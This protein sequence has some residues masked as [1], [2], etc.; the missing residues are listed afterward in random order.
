MKI[1]TATK[2]SDKIKLLRDIAREIFSSD[3]D[4]QGC[5]AKSG[6]SETPWER[7]TYLGAK[8]RAINA[9]QDNKGAD[10]GVG[11][12]TGLSRRFGHIFEETWCCVVDKK[13]NEFWGYASGNVIPVNI[14]KR[15]V[16]DKKTG[17]RSL[18]VFDQKTDSFSV[19]SGDPAIRAVCLS[20]AIRMALTQFVREKD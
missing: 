16:E 3:V 6:V 9:L 17:T 13:G 5:S 4:V 1:Y 7:E 2:N 15:V 14:K 11:I 10:L 18:E 20:N 8:N 19:Y 12:E